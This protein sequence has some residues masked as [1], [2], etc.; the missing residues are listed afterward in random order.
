MSLQIWLPLVS[1][2][3]NQGV[4]GST[5]TNTSVTLDNSGKLGKC[6]Y[7]NGSAYLKGT[8]NPATWT[9]YSVAC[10]VK[11]PTA[12]SGNKQILSIAS[13]SG[14]TNNR[15]SLLYRT[16]SASVVAAIS[17]GTNSTQYNMNMAVTENNWNHIVVT[18]SNKTLKFYLNGVYQKS[19]TTTFDPNFSDITTFGV[20][21]ASNGA[22]KFTGYINDAR[23]YDHA[24]SA[25]EVKE[26]SK[27]LICHYP[28]DGNG[29]GVPNLADNSATFS[30]WT[31]ATGWTLGTSDNGIKMYSF[32]RTGA[33]SN[34]WN[35]LVSTLRVDGNNYPNG[36]TVSMDL[37][38]PDKSAINQKCLGSLQI[39]D[40]NGSRTGWYEPQWD[41]TNVINNQWS[42]IKFTFTQSALLTNSQGLVYS[43]TMFSFQLVQNGNIS[44][45]E[46]KIEEGSV[47]TPYSISVND[48]NSNVEIDTSGYKNNGTR[49]NIEVS[50]ANSPKYMSASY[51]KGSSYIACGRNTMIT[52]AITINVWV[53]SSNWASY[54]KT[55]ASCTES[56]G[57]SFG[58]SGSNF[59]W[60]MGT[61]TSSNTYKT[62]S[63]AASTFTAGWHMIT[64]TYDGLTVKGYVDAVLKGTNAAYTEK[65]PIFYNASNGVFIGAEAGGNQ[66]TPAGSY[67]TCNMSDFRI[68]AA[69][70][71]AD[72]IKELYQTSASITNNG[73][74]ICYD[75]VEN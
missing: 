15:A 36:I 8:I 74:I 13:N 63:I 32:S 67:S 20:G 1:D 19:Y 35:R 42:R 71:S 30:D 62:I 49:T 75:F 73:A 37:L 39:Y 66:T 59:N 52:D 22:E 61:G 46:I 2:F 27:G 33:T 64:V 11:P 17:D 41:F 69:A 12:S 44:I 34:T 40:S 16:S 53:Y 7:F 9:E 70:L 4:Y 6:G 56:G 29:I 3:N 28:L 38:T 14:W 23:I 68:Y 47:A 60:Y 58:I 57:W 24:L 65:T 72:D 25:K 5:I 51:F 45:R 54:I 18:Y 50:N 26:I 48:M 55:L 21:A 10:W 31:A 43:Y